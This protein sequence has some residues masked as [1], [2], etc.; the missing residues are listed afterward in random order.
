[1][2]TSIIIFA[3]IVNLASFMTLDIQIVI[4]YFIAEMI[5]N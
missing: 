5:V 4:R 1:M 3:G 2:S